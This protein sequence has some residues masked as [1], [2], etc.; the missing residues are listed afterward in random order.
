LDL[1]PAGD[2]QAPAAQH[3][4]PRYIEMA[5]QETATR[6]MVCAVLADYRSFDTL[7]EILVIVI[8][9]IAIV[10]IVGI[11]RPADEI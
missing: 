6:N 4:S 3:V 7:G 5:Y 8:A 9:G 11:S 2:H 10:Y 1:P